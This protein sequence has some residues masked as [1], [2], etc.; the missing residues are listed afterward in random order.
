MNNVEYAK[1]Y[2]DMGWRVFPCNLEKQPLTKHGFYDAVL[3]E[4]QI[5]L[6]WKEFPNAS[7]GIATGHLSGIYVVDVDI[8]DK[9]PGANSIATLEAKYG[10]LPVTPISRT[11]SGG[12]QYIFAYPIG[13]KL[14]SSKEKVAPGIDTRGNGGYVVVPPSLHPSGNR[15][16][17]DRE[18]PVSSTPLATPPDWLIWLVHS[19]ES[20]QSAPQQAAEPI[21]GVFPTGSRNDT[22]TSLA[23]TMRRRGMSQESIYNALLVENAN[24]CSPPLPES[25]VRTIALSVSNYT[26]QAAPKTVSRGRMQ[27]EWA[28]AK[29]MYEHPINLSDFEWLKP[30]YFS[31]KTLAE[32]WGIALEIKDTIAAATRSNT[33]S[34]LQAWKDYNPDRVDAYAQEISRYGYLDGISKTAGNLQRLALEGDVS[35]VSQI[36]QALSEAPQLA[37]VAPQD[38]DEGLNELAATLETGAFL[39]TGVGNIDET[40]GGLEMKAM[41]VLAARPGMGKTSLAWQIARNVALTERVLFFSLEVATVKLWRKAALG[42]AE[43]TPSDIFNKK[44]SEQKLR[45]IYDEI[46]PSL[47][48]TY[49]GRLYAYDQITDTDTMWR[50]ATLLRPSLIII[51]HMRYVDDDADNEIQRLGQISKRGKQLAKKIDAHVMFLHQL[52]RG[53]TT[54]EDK[55]PQLTDLRESG[56]VEENADQIFMIHRPDY[57]EMDSAKKR[58]SETQLLIRKNRDDI[59][60]VPFAIYYDLMQQWFYRQN[61]LPPHYKELCLDGRLQRTVSLNVPRS[62]PLQYT[63]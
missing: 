61:E 14:G 48:N 50:M 28:F 57:Y 63:D 31:D 17:W 39:R 29:S 41:S 62:E 3:N 37:T 23:G 42:I 25:D 33:L 22:L 7:I 43:V 36:I 2:I 30:D 47:K 13:E 32:F 34:E 10:K 35:K 11:G 46:I 18:Y 38:A 1:R 16:E 60:G 26:A 27:C 40:I 6:W 15:Y 44:V 45:Q 53:V 55:A 56:H 59:S 52:N 51:D 5:D 58:Y 49:K 24:R 8:K 20:P 4:D 9:K 12:W 19:A 54:R 21:E